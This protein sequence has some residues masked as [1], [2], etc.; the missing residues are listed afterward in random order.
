MIFPFELSRAQYFVRLIILIVGVGV[1][2]ALLTPL[3]SATNHLSSWWLVFLLITKVVCLDIPRLRHM[4]SSPWH[5]LWAFVP[6]ANLI[7]QLCLFFR[8][9]AK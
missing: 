4:G 7:L 6:L 9:P 3:I 5:A 1:I 8:G 2:A